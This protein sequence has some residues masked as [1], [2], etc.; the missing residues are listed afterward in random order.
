MVNKVGIFFIVEPGRLEYQVE[1]FVKS[2]RQEGGIPTELP[3]YCFQPRKSGKLSRRTFQ[4]FDENNVIFEKINLNKKFFFFPLANKILTGAYFEK[5]YGMLFERIIFFDSDFLIQRA[6]EN[7][8]TGSKP[9]GLTPEFV[10]TWAIKEGSKP[11]LMWRIILDQL[12]LN[13]DDFWYTKTFVDDQS[14]LAYYNSGLISTQPNLSL[15]TKWLG[16]FYQVMKDP[17]ILKLD[18]NAFYF[19]EMGSLAATLV[20]TWN[21]NDIQELPPD[22]NLPLELTLEGVEKA[23]FVHYMD[24]FTSFDFRS[25]SIKNELKKMIGEAIKNKQEAPWWVR[26]LQIFQFQFFKLR[27]KAKSITKAT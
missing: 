25:L 4:L 18:P 12:S 1:I 20:K 8:I 7:L 21:K 26:F 14:I 24:Y 2:L 13:T 27:L 22:L 15:F 23:A 3:I 6:V 17:R 9:I 19:L 10:S 5:K 16:S 11:S